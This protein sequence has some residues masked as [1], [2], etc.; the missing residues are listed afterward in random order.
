M[1]KVMDKETMQFYAEIVCLTGPMDLLG[2]LYSLDYVLHFSLKISILKSQ[3]TILYI[4]L[5]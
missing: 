3:N 2:L 4:L 5:K 1:F